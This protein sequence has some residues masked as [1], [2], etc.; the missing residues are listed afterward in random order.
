MNIE[1]VKMAITRMHK[2]I[3]NLIYLSSLKTFRKR[4]FVALTDADI[5]DIEMVEL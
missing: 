5:R 1:W 2:H 3:V 4:L